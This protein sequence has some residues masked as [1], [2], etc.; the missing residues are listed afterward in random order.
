MV[1]VL[2]PSY[3]DA[4]E[5]KETLLAKVHAAVRFREEHLPEFETSSYA[6]IDRKLGSALR[7]VEIVID[8]GDKLA[9]S[10]KDAIK[11]AW[12]RRLRNCLAHGVSI[13]T[14]PV[15]TASQRRSSTA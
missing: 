9:E 12:E 2:E 15:D 6:S 13:L 1:E 8:V 7:G 3:Y 5:I 14:S 11:A 10:I 4:L